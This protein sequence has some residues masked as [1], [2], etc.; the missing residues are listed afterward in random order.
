L[1]HVIPG[2]MIRGPS[3]LIRQEILDPNQAL[4]SYRIEVYQK[5]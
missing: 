4:E 5:R 1:S 2:E 3:M